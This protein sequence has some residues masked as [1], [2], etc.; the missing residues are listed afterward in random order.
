MLQKTI[1]ILLALILTLSLAAC[2]SQSAAPTEPGPT[3]SVQDQLTETTQATQP[4]AITFRETVLVDN[5]TCLFK[6]TAIE[7][8]SIWGYTLKAY[9]ENRSQQNLMFS[10][11]GT[12]VN[13][14][15]CDPFWAAEV[16]PGMKANEEI[17]F[18]DTALSECGIT[19]ITDIT[20]TLVIYDADNYS[21]EYLVS[22]TFT[23]YPM[24]QEAV[25]PYVRTAVEGE[26]VLFD[27]DS[28]AM[29]VTGTKNDSIWGYSLT[30]YLENR[31]DKALMFSASDVSVNGFMCDPYWATEVTP[32]KRA[33]TTISWLPG[34]LEDNG[35]TDVE[36]IVMPITVYDPA[37]W[38]ADPILE[39][40]FTIQPKF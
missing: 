1:S 19:S 18:S 39:E 40:T 8:D 10:L 31:T 23:L 28:A 36:S 38:M 20:S 5:E 24:G 34:T 14:F 17:S 3:D 2:G 26:L 16:T 4:P 9:L 13:G 22:E 25:Q 15:M 7:D 37:N 30:V 21:G 33:I 27:N 32:G 11:N 6:I 12:S 35:I 29:I